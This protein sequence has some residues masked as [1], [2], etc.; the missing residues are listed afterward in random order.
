MEKTGWDTEDKAPCTVP[1][2][3]RHTLTMRL[4]SEVTHTS[5]FA[6]GVQKE[7]KQPPF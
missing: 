3:R 7:E 1:G 4:F 2:T 5:A 6:P